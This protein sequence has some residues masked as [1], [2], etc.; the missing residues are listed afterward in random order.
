MPVGKRFELA[1]CTTR[2]GPDVTVSE[3]VEGLADLVS[4]LSRW[5][6]GVADSDA[7][8]R[9]LARVRIDAARVVELLGASV[10]AFERAEAEELAA[11]RGRAASAPPP[12]AKPYARKGGPGHLGMRILEEIDA[13]GEDEPLSAVEIA[14]SLGYAVAA[15]HASLR[16]LRR[17]G[18]VSNERRRGLGP[19][20]GS[21]PVPCRLTEA[22][23]RAL[24][25]SSD[26]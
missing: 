9:R 25:E 13:R 4:E 23:R 12:A 10:A 1:R 15:I 8:L 5:R 24:S 21:A 14:S 2:L 22:G 11:L 6:R 18:F 26:L 17:R 7:L 20:N 16:I 3:T 19:G